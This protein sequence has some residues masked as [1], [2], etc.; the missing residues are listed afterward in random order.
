[1]TKRKIDLNVCS[2]RRCWR[3]TVVHRFTLKLLLRGRL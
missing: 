2:M 1:M 3:S